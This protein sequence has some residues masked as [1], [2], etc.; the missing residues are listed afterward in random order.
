[1]L[2]FL[3]Q[4]RV[5]D[6]NALLCFV[7]FCDPAALRLLAVSQEVEQSMNIDDFSPNQKG[8]MLW[9]HSFT[10]VTMGSMCLWAVLNGSTKSLCVQTPSP[11]LSSHP[12]HEPTVPAQPQLWNKHPRLYTPIDMVWITGGSDTLPP[13]GDKDNSLDDIQL[14]LYK[15]GNTSQLIFSSHRKIIIII[16]M[17]TPLIW[18]VLFS[19]LFLPTELAHE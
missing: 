6:L 9:M 12:H 17:W 10:L 11:Q 16:I 2:L 8:Q 7:L 19:R 3:S 4:H 5:I 15:N 1:M 13:L 18:T 14:L